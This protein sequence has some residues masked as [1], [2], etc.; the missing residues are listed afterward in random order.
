MLMWYTTYG[1]NLKY[2][3]NFESSLNYMREELALNE[4]QKTSAQVAVDGLAISPD[5]H[6]EW[7]QETEERD[8]E[9]MGETFLRGVIVGRVEESE[10][11]RQEHATS[12][13]DP[14]EVDEKISSL[15]Q[16]TLEE[17]KS[18]S[19]LNWLIRPN[20]LPEEIK[21]K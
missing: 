18:L 1:L 12:I 3:E 21:E 7:V 10:E 16:Q 9:A 17:A 20:F 19:N 2:P 15:I 13:L 6:L 11:A 5:A 8:K 4:F 14:S